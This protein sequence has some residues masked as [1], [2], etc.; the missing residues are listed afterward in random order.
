MMQDEIRVLIEKG[1]ENQRSWIERLLKSEISAQLSSHLSVLP[2]IVVDR[3]ANEHNKGAQG[4]FNLGGARAG[5][6]AVPKGDNDFPAKEK[7]EM[8]NGQPQDLVALLDVTD[9]NAAKKASRKAA[10]TSRCQT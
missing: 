7:Q 4:K 6:P 3:I 8:T 10:T 1:F 2:D 5:V 9:Q